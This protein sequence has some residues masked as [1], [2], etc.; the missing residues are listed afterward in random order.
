MEINEQ[1]GAKS[2]CR[3]CADTS[4]QITFLRYTHTSK[5]H[6][7]R[8]ATCCSGRRLVYRSAAMGLKISGDNLLQ[9]Q[10]VGLSICY[11]R[12]ED[13]WQRPAAMAEGQFIDLLL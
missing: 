12:V 3:Y 11:H 13:Q 6:H 8:R 9:W 4:L 2:G 5:P 1:K 7:L 10:K